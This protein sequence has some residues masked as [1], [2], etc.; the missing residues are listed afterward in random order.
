MKPPRPKAASVRRDKPGS[1]HG[2]GTLA[3]HLLAATPLI[4][5]VT[6]FVF[7]A[8]HFGWLNPLETTSLDFLLR[9]REPVRPEY[10]WLVAITD[11]DYADPK[12]F[13]KTSPL[14]PGKL[15]AVIEAISAGNPRV[16]G[17]DV[18]TSDSQGVRPASG[19]VPI[20]WWQGISES[21]HGHE[22]HTVPVLGNEQPQPSAEALGVYAIPEESDGA[23]RR[24]SRKIPVDH[25]QVD[26]LPWAVVKVYCR[27]VLDDPTAAVELKRKC[28]Q[29]LRSESLSKYQKPTLLTF[30]EPSHR[31][32]RFISASDVLANS[33]AWKQEIRGKIVMLGGTFAVARDSYRTPLGPRTGVELLCDAVETELQRRPVTPLNEVFMVIL[34]LT[35]GY[36]L[37]IWHFVSRNWGA[38]VLRV[39][40]IPALALASSFLAFASLAYWVNFVPVLTGVLAHEVYDHFKHHRALVRRVRELEG[41]TV[42]RKRKH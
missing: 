25:G 11:E 12:L 9:L 42:E 37:T 35:G 13:G 4:L 40:A 8:H 32:K 34:E 20:V 17:V 5:G 10:V 7:F 31:Q 26:S 1:A 21:E 24:Y 2:G 39:L 22:R 27:R 15:R 30:S 41:A 28:E 36:L 19:E 38:F 29:V 3:S 16:I 23:A 33:D 14:N 6:V 18:D